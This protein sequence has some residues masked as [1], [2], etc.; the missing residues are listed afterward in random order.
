MKIVRTESTNGLYSLYKGRSVMYV[1]NLSQK[2]RFPGKHTADAR[3]EAEVLWDFT[4]V[5]FANV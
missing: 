5:F 3:I 1:F 2:D 4:Y